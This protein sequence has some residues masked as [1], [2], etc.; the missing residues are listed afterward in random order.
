MV[1]LVIICVKQHAAVTVKVVNQ[2]IKH[3]TMK[4]TNN[5]YTF[6]VDLTSA[7]TCEDVKLEFIKA[8]A[9]QGKKID[10]DEF[11]FI[12]QYGAQLA[13]DTIDI[14]I[15]AFLKSDK[16]TKIEDDD[17]AK[18]ILKLVEKKI[19]PKKPWYKRFWSWLTKPFKKNK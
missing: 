6:V 17:L 1:L 19:K 14:C 15:D 11:K 9:L 5:K 10:M 8:K 4:K 12:I 3:K 16:Y 18:D 13:F 7:E 2:N